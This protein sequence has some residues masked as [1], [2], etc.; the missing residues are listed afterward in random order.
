MKTK[1]SD[2]IYYTFSSQAH[3]IDKILPGT[4]CRPLGPTRRHRRDD[5]VG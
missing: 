2:H 1:V 4:Q 3:R 5:V